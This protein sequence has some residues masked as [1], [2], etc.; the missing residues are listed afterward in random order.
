MRSFTSQVD[1]KHTGSPPQLIIVKDNFWKLQYV[2]LYTLEFLVSL[3]TPHEPEQ[4][5]LEYSN[6]RQE[7][8]VLSHLSYCANHLPL[9]QQTIAKAE[10]NIN[11]W[12]RRGLIISFCGCSGVFTKKGI[13][14][15]NFGSE[16]KRL[17]GQE[18][19]SILNAKATL[20]GKK[21]HL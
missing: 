7:L 1:A 16:P 4:T 21:G 17:S 20:I 14:R 15:N 6:H 5:L 2:N 9:S 12:K 10:E 11:R 8:D 13:L 18:A 19:P 3:S